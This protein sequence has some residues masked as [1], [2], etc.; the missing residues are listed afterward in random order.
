MAFR[1]GAVPLLFIIGVFN[2]PTRPCPA[3][4]MGLGL[5]STG[6]AWSAGAASDGVSQYEPAF[7]AGRS[8]TALGTC[9]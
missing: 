1:H 8:A 4:N 5:L 6:A 9:R 2:Q 3:L 7:A